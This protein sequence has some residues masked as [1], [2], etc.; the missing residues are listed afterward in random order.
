MD[1]FLVPLGSGRSELYCET[2]AELHETEAEAARSGWLRRQIDRFKQTLAEAEEE[3]RRRERGE[4]SEKTGIW[5]KLIGKIAEAVAEQRL[6]WRLRHETDAR[7]VHAADLDGA[8]AIDAAREMCRADY[9]KHRRWVFIDGLLAA[10][11]GPGLFFVPGPNVIAYYF[12]FRAVGHYFSMRGARPARGS[13]RS[14]TRSGW[15][16][17]PRSPSA[18]PRGRRDLRWSPALQGRRI[19]RRPRAPTPG[20][21]SPRTRRELATA[22]T[23]GNRRLNRPPTPQQVYSARR[24]SERAGVA[25]GLPPRRRRNDRRHARRGPRRRRT[26]RRHLPG[27]LTLRLPARLH[28]R[29]RGDRR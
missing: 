22:S 16:I 26:D 5:R 17:S 15:N 8:R 13:I 11:L 28:P 23:P 9:A 1:V 21:R 6:L 10:I 25:P 29:R 20:P 2:P 12:V 18:L 4:P 27:Q 19:R 14:R 3:R 7:L 24:D